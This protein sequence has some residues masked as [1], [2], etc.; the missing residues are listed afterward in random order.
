MSNKTVVSSLIRYNDSSIFFLVCFIGAQE[1]INGIARVR[2]QKDS[3]H[4]VRI[5]FFLP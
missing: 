1:I 5:H 3:L 2:S 4:F